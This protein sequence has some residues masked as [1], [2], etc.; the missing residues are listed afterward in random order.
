MT[1]RNDLPASILFTCV[2]IAA[3]MLGGCVED[4]KFQIQTVELTNSQAEVAR[5][6]A[7]IA[8]EQGRTKQANTQAA[9]ADLAAKKA[10]AAAEAKAARAQKDLDAARAENKAAATV[11]EARVA[12]A[13]GEGAKAAMGL[14]TA[15]KATSD[16]KAET[17]AAQEQARTAE[18][19]AMILQAQ[20]DK[21][22][23]QV[24][25]LGKKIADLEKQLS[26]AK[27]TRDTPRHE[28]GTI[29]E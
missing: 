19:K 14:V 8:A 22:T 7:A 29:T 13:Q 23:A 2:A 3:G 11:A 27:A 24:A 12:T 9:I 21:L 17:R 26:D 1:G 18:S 20:V 25:E 5:L 4:E 28:E 16:A 6:K 10:L 15:Q